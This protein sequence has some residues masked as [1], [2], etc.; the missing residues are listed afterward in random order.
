[1]QEYDLKDFKSY[2]LFER[3]LSE[4]TVQGYM[5]DIR[6]FYEYIDYDI[7]KFDLS[8]IDAYFCELKDDG[9]KVTSIRRKIVSLR[10]YNEF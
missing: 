1:M 6:A 4:N 5:R 10:Q 7:K 3:G 2:L 9:Y 8:H